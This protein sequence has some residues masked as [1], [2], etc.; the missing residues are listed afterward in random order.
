MGTL[1]ESKE[2]LR[3]R[4]LEVHLT[5]TEVDA[6]VANAITSLARLAFAASQP[7]T[8]P[9]DE[10][11]TALF[12]AAVI[13]NV[14]T[15]ASIKRLV[16]EAQTLVIADV[17]NRATKKDDSAPTNMA[18]AE[19][20]NRINEQRGRLTGLRLRGEEEV[21]H[22]VYDLLLGMAEKDVLVY[23][24][25]EKFHTRRQ[26]LLN[27]KPAKELAI[28]ASSLVVKEK[29]PDLVCPTGTELEVVNALHRRAL[30]YD[31]TQLCPYDVMNGFHAELIDH[32]TQPTPP[33]YSPISLHQILRA[34]RAAFMVMSE[35]FTSLKKDIN[36]KT[37]IE[38]ALPT[39]LSHS[40]V[41]FHL[42]PL[43][44]HAPVE[45]PVPKATVKPERQRSRSPKPKPK[46]K[47]AGKGKTKKKGRG[48][49]VPELLIGKTKETKDGRRL[50]WAFNL[51]NGCSKALAGGSCDRGVHLCAE[52]GCQKAHSL[53]NHPSA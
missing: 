19:R 28:D 22:A 39:I 18:P 8:T 21:G 34:D 30:A 25:P 13:P 29:P 50:C 4:A 33:G 7:G 1:L 47:G 9:T 45:K 51:P 23:H 41:S 36:G 48:P 17:K 53:Q 3:A 46:A 10:Q 26:E 43:A 6:I 14:G 2:A 35:K 5:E 16:F 40:A 12:G 31:L 49:N 44:K 37:A 27:K 11:V 38:K 20:E 24:G 15:L 42:L 32:L 52:P